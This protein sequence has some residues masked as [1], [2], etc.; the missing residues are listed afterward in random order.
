MQR[1]LANIESSKETVAILRDFA[2]LA[3][4][5]LRQMSVNTESQR[6]L[7]CHKL[8]LASNGKLEQRGYSTRYSLMAWIGLF[9]A[10]GRPLLYSDSWRAAERHFISEIERRPSAFALSDLGLLFWLS[11]YAQNMPRENLLRLIGERWRNEKHF[12]NTMEGALLLAGLTAGQS[13]LSL[14]AGYSVPAELVAHLAAAFQKGSRLFT[15][16]RART[17][18][19]RPSRWHY[20]V[21]ASFASQVY[22]LFA[23]S[24]Y[25]R[26]RADPDISLMVQ[27]AVD[28]ICAWQG[29]RGEW[30]WM[31]DARRSRVLLDYPVY[32]VHQYGMGP[33]TL[34]AAARILPASS[35]SDSINR[36]LRYV[37][38]Y[39]HPD[40]G[41]GLIDQERSMI[42]RAV[43]RDYPGDP[44]DL[45]FGISAHEARRIRPNWLSRSAREEPLDRFR[46]LKEA[47]PYS[48]GW[49]LLAY[50]L[51][52]EAAGESCCSGLAQF[53]W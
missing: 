52:C 8:Y 13:D 48:L 1:N 36:S 14:T 43:I 33:M 16:N 29:P 6:G 38:E 17:V 27:Q 46:I 19:T 4:S 30:W 51:A 20:S 24:C 44:C 39:Q 40:T 35:L 22:P 15:M 5:M 3:I 21:V 47:R 25:L 18:I 11:E 12:V 37:L 23:L 7:F 28:E 10:L 45:P 53:T 32:S 34:L 26:H 2:P 31:Y 9:S 50:S 49:L 42:W 41:E